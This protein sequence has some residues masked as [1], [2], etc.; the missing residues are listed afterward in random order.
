MPLA[1]VTPLAW[2]PPSTATP[3][4]AFCVPP[5]LPTVRGRA[6]AAPTAPWRLGQPLQRGRQL[7]RMFDEGA[8][9]GG[10]RPP[11]PAPMPRRKGP[12]IRGGSSGGGRAALKAEQELWE[13]RR[14]ISRWVERRARARAMR[15]PGDALY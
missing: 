15:G 6:A 11:A 2:H 13:A 7:L 9:G 1:T 12:G 10:E 8:G 3:A 5:L 14:N 4:S